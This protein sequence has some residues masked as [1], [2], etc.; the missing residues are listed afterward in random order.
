MK[1]NAHKPRQL[2]K[3]NAWY[4]LPLGREKYVTVYQYNPVKRSQGAIIIKLN[5]QKLLRELLTIGIKP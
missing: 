2:R 1:V 4:Y 5:A 3:Q